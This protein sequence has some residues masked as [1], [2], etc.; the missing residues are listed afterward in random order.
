[1]PHALLTAA[2]RQRV[3]Q[4]FSDLGISGEGEFRESLLIRGGAYCGR[5]FDA[6]RGHAIWFVEEDE[7]KFY[8][9]DGKLAEVVATS[10]V[11]PLTERIAA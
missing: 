11:D 10:S 6:P 4:T 1:M 9:A 8:G 3:A 7:I 2:V 5:R